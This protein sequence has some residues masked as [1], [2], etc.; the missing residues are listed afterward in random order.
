M[1]MLSES[2]SPVPDKTGAKIKICGIR[3]LQDI[4]YVN[5]Y[6]P[7]YIGYIFADTKRKVSDREAARLTAALDTSI[8]PVGVF[9]NDRIEHIVSLCNENIIQCIQLHGDESPSYIS[10]L[11]EQ[12]RKPVIKAVRVRSTEQLIQYQDFPC[13]YLLL[14]TYV[15]NAYGGTGQCFDRTMIPKNYRPFFL[16]GGLGPANMLQAMEEC[17]PYCID[18]SSSVETDGYKDF[19]KIK[20]V[21]D[22]MNQW[23]NRSVHELKERKNHD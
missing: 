22:I 16:A 20:R 7:D 21:M 6:K 19:E 13:D 1:V 2:Y 9:V 10:R 17:H 5:C 12:T 18:L 11:R 4:D 3:R 23:K 15:K 8:V 14:D